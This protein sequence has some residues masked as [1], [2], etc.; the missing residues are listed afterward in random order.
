[1]ILFTIIGCVIVA[2]AVIGL[3]ATIAA[4]GSFIIAYA[5]IIVCALLVALIVRFIIRRKRK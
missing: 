4:G 2:L 3:F 1:M 5:D